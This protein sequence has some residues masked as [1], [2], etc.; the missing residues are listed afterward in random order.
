MNAENMLKTGPKMHKTLA[1]RTARAKLNGLK[2]A[3]CPTKIFYFWD[4]HG[5]RRIEL[6]SAE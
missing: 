4:K 5:I 3:V 1:S 2:T 6:F